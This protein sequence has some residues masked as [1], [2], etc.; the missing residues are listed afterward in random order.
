[1]LYDAG[2][3]LLVVRRG[4]QPAPTTGTW[5]A[6]MAAGDAALLAA[7]GPGP[8]TFDL[9]A[10]VADPPLFE[11]ANQ[12]ADSARGTPEAVAEFHGIARGGDRFTLAVVGHG[13]RAVQVE[14]DPAATSV[15]FTRDGQAVG[16]Q[17]LP[18]PEMGF[19]SRE[20]ALLGG[21]NMAATIPPG[22][23]GAMAFQVPPPPG[24]TA[25]YLKVSGW[26]RAALPDEEQPARFE[27][28][29]TERPL[30]G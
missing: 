16:W 23:M 19:M 12:A 30:P 27:I 28:L 24:A 22:A 9:L 17:P 7:A 14:L 1:M 5:S 25:V 2:P 4:R 10:A 8:V 13:T 3:A 15:Q 26:L 20:G 11:A 18:A 21:L 29:T 6:A